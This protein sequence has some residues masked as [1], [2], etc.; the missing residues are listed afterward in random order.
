[1]LSKGDISG[2]EGMLVEVC[3]NV[4]SPL[5]FETSLLVSVQLSG[6]EVASEL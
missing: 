5:F 6:S 3:V 4:T 1:M 2:E